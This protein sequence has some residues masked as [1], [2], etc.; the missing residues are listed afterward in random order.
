[1][2]YERVN[3]EGKHGWNVGSRARGT[4]EGGVRG[5]GQRAQL[6]CLLLWCFHVNDRRTNCMK[7]ADVKN[8]TR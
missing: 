8:E 5:D 1:M 7:R 4:G 2:V 3:G 6:L